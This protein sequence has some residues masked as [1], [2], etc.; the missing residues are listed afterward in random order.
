MLMRAPNKGPVQETVVIR[1]CSVFELLGLERL[2]KKRLGGKGWMSAM[3][4]VFI[5][6]GD[7]DYIVCQYKERSILIG[8]LP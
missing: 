4:A 7:E 1:D 2:F 6:P 8:Q 3:E 5:F